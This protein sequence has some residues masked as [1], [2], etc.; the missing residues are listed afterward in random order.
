MPLLVFSCIIIS[1]DISTVIILDGKINNA[2]LYLK[3]FII[4]VYFLFEIRFGPANRL[5]VQYN[6]TSCCK[7]RKT[8]ADSELSINKVCMNKDSSESFKEDS[9]ES[10]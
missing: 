10:L 5:L 3:I 1:S 7:L 2:F 4:K 9:S 8:F 6:N